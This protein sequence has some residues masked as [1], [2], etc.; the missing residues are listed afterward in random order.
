MDILDGLNPSQREA[1]EHT[2]GPLLVLAG[3]GSGKTRVITY[4]I[5]YLVKAKLVSPD[6]ILA[7][8]FTN[9]AAD[10]M[11]KRV[12]SLVGSALSVRVGTFHSTA[13]AFLREYIQHTPYEGTFSVI[14]RDEALSLVRAAIK[15]L[16]LDPKLFS[17]KKYLHAISR[18]KNT[19]D[20]IEKAEAGEEAE[21]KFRD[22]FGRY[23]K[24]L[25][26]QRLIDFDDMLALCVRILL[27]NPE[28]LEEYKRGIKYILVDEYQDTNAVQFA[29]LR[30]LAGSNGNLCVV[31]DDDQS[32]YSFRGAEISNI[33][34][35]ERHFE[36]VREIKL[37]QN[38]RS[39]E[40][41]LTFA[42]NLIRRNFSRRGKNLTAVRGEKGEVHFRNFKDEKAEA[43][44]LADRA[45]EWRFS[46][47]S[48][49]DMAVLY[50]TNAQS[51]SF[52][53]ALKRHAIPY[54]VVG[55]VGFYQRREIKD[56]LS[57]LRI[58]DNPFD[59][60]SF[61]RAVK[62]PPRGV[63]DQLIARIKAYSEM[64]RCDLLTAASQVAFAV[65][66]KQAA[67]INIFLNIILEIN[68]APTLT[69]KVKA[70]V[71]RSDY[72]QYLFDS[73]EKEAAA[74]REENVSEL[75][76]SATEF[77]E[78]YPKASLSDFL[79]AAALTTSA[80]EREEGGTVNLMTI[81]AAKGL[82]FDSVF[83][84]GLEEGIFPIGS[85]KEGD[86]D[87]EE[88][89]RLCY[90]AITRAKTF[91]TFASAQSR[92]MHGSR[93]KM[94][95]SRFLG[96]ITQAEKKALGVGSAIIH[97]VFGEGFII[98]LDTDGE[99]S[100]ADVMFRRGGRKRIR[101]DFL[102]AQ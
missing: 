44:F 21:E 2:E 59:E 76:S 49:S 18:H 29:F 11:K 1:A 97:E 94:S 4:R 68:A 74:E 73:E 39:A 7:V 101:A 52:E 45:F 98:A 38:Y 23:S 33:L 3:A 102:R 78:Q 26:D 70:A 60:A 5:A 22:I 9:K 100:I 61:T 16:G 48:L 95:P 32:I 86:F 30:I 83:L 47:R 57:Y 89:R 87:L 93:R 84:A 50:R 77:S 19:M 12:K 28:V 65:S 82:E 96:E 91:L 63:G 15:D 64:E 20:Y 69:D 34:N 66:Q 46:G 90:V 8:T 40:K 41:I 42:N 51:R 6:A 80:D 14:E 99:I 37:T 35:F 81:H 31:G 55:G 56:I 36:N 72:K 75:I 13:L 53:T 92:I 25:I 17:P 54:K 67:G 85:P 58:L 27:N 24:A 88:E 79:A 10:E 71:E 62:M 43:D